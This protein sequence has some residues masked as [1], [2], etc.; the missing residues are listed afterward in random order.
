MGKILQI[1]KEI[2]LAVLF[3]DSDPAA[4]EDDDEPEDRCI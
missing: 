2:V 1:I 3:I 4:G